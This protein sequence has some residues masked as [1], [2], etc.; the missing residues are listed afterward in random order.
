[1][2]IFIDVTWLP[3]EKLSE[4]TN[5]AERQAH[6]EQSRPRRDHVGTHP[7]ITREYSDH[8]AFKANA[9]S[10]RYILANI[11]DARDAGSSRSPC[12]WFA[13]PTDT[14]LL[15]PVFSCSSSHAELMILRAA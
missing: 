14:V 12:M 15:R 7:D 8:E 13:K 9:R 5:P 2:L 11:L 6:I 4:I 10:A 1:M 3:D